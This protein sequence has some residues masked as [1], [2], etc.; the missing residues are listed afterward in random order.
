MSFAHSFRLPASR[1]VQLAWVAVILL[2]ASAFIPSFHR[3]PRAW[4]VEKVPIAFWAWRNESPAEGDVRAAI[5]KAHAR[6]LFLRA[7]QID[8]QFGK[9]R[10]IRPVTGSLPVGIDLH[11]VYNATR[12]LLAQLEAVDE[13]AMADSISIWVSGGDLARGFPKVQL[14]PYRTA[15]VSGGSTLLT[16]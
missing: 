3:K 13:N 15:V 14:D 16:Y 6:I 10:R 9:L 7:G 2:I 1:N 4:Q 12:Y 8:F 11:L 5:E